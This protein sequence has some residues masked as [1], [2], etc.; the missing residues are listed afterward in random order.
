M[1]RL[2]HQHKTTQQQVFQLHQQQHQ[3]QQQQ[4]QYHRQ[5]VPLS[6]E[7]DNPLPC[8]LGQK[9]TQQMS[10]SEP[11]FTV[12]SDPQAHTLPPI[13][14]LRPHPVPAPRASSFTSQC[15]DNQVNASTTQHT[16]Q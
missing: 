13:S 7:M 2:G 14:V 3:Q 1:P 9:P 8:V 11:N 6:S 5:T 12:Y 15:I 16:K 4:Q 10:A